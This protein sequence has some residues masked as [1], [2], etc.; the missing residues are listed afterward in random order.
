[1]MLTVLIP[2]QSKKRYPPEGVTESRND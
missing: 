1:M 2:L